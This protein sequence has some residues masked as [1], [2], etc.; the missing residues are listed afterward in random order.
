MFTV[1]HRTIRNAG[2]V[3]LWLVA[4]AVIL[5]TL[6]SAIP[7][8]QWWF[9]IWDFPRLFVM[10]IGGLVL[11]GLFFCRFRFR[12]PL[13]AALAVAIAYQ[14]G[15]IYPYTI[16]SPVEAEMV[17]VD[18]A[19]REG[20]C[21][22][23]FSLNVLQDNRDY[24]RS[25]DAIEEADADLLLLM[26]TDSNWLNAVQPTL[27]RYPH[28]FEAPLSN[29]Y[30]MALATRLDVETAEILNLAEPRTPSV[31]AVMRTPAGRR[32]RL[33]A[34]HPRPPHPG[35][36]TEE[37]DA[38]IAIAAMMTRDAGLPA[39]TLGDFNDVG[40]SET[41]QLFRRIGRYVDPRIGRG[42]Y[43]TFPASLPGFRWPLDHVF[44]TEEFAIR[45]LSVGD[46]VGSDHLPVH[47]EVCLIPSTGRA[48][49]RPE[50]AEADDED[51]LQETL[52]AYHEDEV[53]ERRTGPD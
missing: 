44:F 41:S 10:T 1:S 5:V 19:T 53:V 34:L 4:I 51:D 47:T 8:S 9:R 20:H 37:R 22:T 36:D 48:N 40:W 21:F 50:Q 35:Q 23:A 11:I 14:A 30:G 3:A 31:H 6:A 12:W 16:L 26:E 24:R 32:F 17:E 28:R 27:A 43:A 25:I 49:N 46:P 15:H 45:S 2:I 39:F 29:R 7:S 52:R 38:E 33:A 42:F 18:A 13:A